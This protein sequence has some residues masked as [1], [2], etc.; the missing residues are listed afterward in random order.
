MPKKAPELPSVAVKRL[1][2]KPGMHA[3]GGVSGLH[4]NVSHTLAAS[5]VLKKKVGS[6]R[7]EMGLGGYPDV[8]L[9]HAR[10]KARAYVDLI[11]EGINPLEDKRK[12]RSALI[13]AQASAISFAEAV[14]NAAALEG[15]ATDKAGKAWR[16]KL[17]YALPILGNRP[18]AEIER[19]DIVNVLMPL[20]TEKTRT[21][22]D[23]RK[24]VEDVIDRAYATNNIGR[25]N[26]ARWDKLLKNMLP[27]QTKKTTNFASLPY[28]LIN[29]FLGEL[30][31]AG[32]NAALAVE[33]A[34]YTGARSGEVCGATWREIDIDRKLWT[35]PAER[36]KKGEEHRI[37]LSKPALA[38][39]NALP[40]G[41]KASD[42]IFPTETG[43]HHQ[44][45]RLSVLV[46]EIAQ[47]LGYAAT[48]HGMRA[49]FRTWGE[50]ET[51][52]P[53]PILEMA[54]AHKIDDA[55]KAAYQRGDLLKKRRKLMDDWADY[56]SA[57]GPSGHV[58]KIGRGNA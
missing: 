40:K 56:C 21:A 23:V 26:P 8:P 13:R 16:F 43:R 22:R 46:R 33:F 51:D 42:P 55:V 5:W 53:E 34:I 49:T 17:G 31:N 37:H 47:K 41:Q 2:Q 25:H 9:T 38:I 58:V 54:L 48:V 24:L 45:A 12:K 3:V 44:N 50:E 15:I 27:K 6:R 14:E 39:L 29:G 28:P 20:W 35:I 32:N 19:E 36:M 7:Q 1:A 18:V 30:K 11:A 4:L 57:P 10:D 52:Y